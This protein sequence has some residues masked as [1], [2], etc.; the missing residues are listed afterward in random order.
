MFA[1]RSEVTA[2]LS[3]DFLKLV[4]T[5]I[6]IATP[7]ALW[8]M[9]TWLQAYTYRIEIG[10]VKNTCHLFIDGMYQRCSRKIYKPFN[11][12]INSF[13]FISIFRILDI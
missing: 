13:I 3:K 12:G 1:S 5:D 9:N 10:T 8:V 11:Q 6:L 2:L 7:I 4:G